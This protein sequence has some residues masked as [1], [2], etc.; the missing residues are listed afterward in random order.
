MKATFDIQNIEKNYEVIRFLHVLVRGLQ[1]SESEC[2]AS[3][4]DSDDGKWYRFEAAH[5][6]EEQANALANILTTVYGRQDL[7]KWIA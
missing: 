6:T 1:V 2:W 4:K 3:D 7:V 5:L